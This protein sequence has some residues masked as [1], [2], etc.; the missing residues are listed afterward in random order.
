MVEV[1]SAFSAPISPLS[2]TTPARPATIAA[3]IAASVA[4]HDGAAFGAERRIRYRRSERQCLLRFG[5][6]GTQI[7][8]FPSFRCGIFCTQEFC[9][10]PAEDIIHDR[11]GVRNL[12]IAR[13]AA[14]LE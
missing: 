2:S 13:P 9:P 11:F 12:R 14:R 10:E 1:R 5:F 8:S 6:C 3:L 7:R 4:G